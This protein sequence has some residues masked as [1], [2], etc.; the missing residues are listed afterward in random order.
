MLIDPRATEN[1]L[2]RSIIMKLRLTLEK[3]TSEE[4]EL[5]NGQT[6]LIEILPRS[7]KLTIDQYNKEIEW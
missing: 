3:D 1:F 5:L 4:V 2:S 6:E 7:I